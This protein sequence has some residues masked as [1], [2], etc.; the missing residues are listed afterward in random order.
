MAAIV[1][2]RKRRRRRLLDP[3]NAAAYEK[4]GLASKL[5]NDRPSAA[6]YYL[7][8]VERCEPGT[9]DWGAIMG[10]AFNELMQP[11]AATTP[12]PAWWNDQLCALEGRRRRRTLN[13]EHVEDALKS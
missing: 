2:P 5:S 7:M 1:M 8:A 6:K 4:L 10:D 11:G 12:P 3:D 9:Q 13:V